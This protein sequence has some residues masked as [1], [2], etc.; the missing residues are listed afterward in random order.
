[1]EAAEALEVVARRYWSPKP[2]PLRRIRWCTWQSAAV[3]ISEP[4]SQSARCHA[5]E[6]ADGGDD[7]GACPT[8]T[9][10]RKSI[11]FFKPVV[12]FSN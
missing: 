8:I 4:L 3:V 11:S 10:C 7:G 9:R 2:S 6:G 1:M 12:C 5:V